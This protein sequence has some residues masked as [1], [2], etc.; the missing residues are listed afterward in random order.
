MMSPTAKTSS[1]TEASLEYTE[2][3]NKCVATPRARQLSAMAPDALIGTEINCINCP[4]I[5]RQSLVNVVAR[6]MTTR[7]QRY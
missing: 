1:E 5:Y 6:L 7:D 2:D 3:V 4:R